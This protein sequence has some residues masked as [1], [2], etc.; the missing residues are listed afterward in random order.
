MMKPNIFNV[1]TKELSQDGFF[2]WLLQWADPS[3]D[4]YNKELCDCAQDFVKKLIAKQID[5]KTEI[6][7]VKAG[8]QWKNIDIWAEVNDEVLI[9][10]EDKTFTGEHSNQLETY[11][12]TATEWC[13]E[14]N[15]KLVC[16][17]LKTGSEALIS[18][19]KITNKGFAVV[20]RPE[21]ILFFNEH[22][23]VKSDIYTDFI[24]RLQSFEVLENSFK[25]LTIKEWH[26]NS[27]QGFYQF[28]QTKIDVTGWRYVA[29]PA[30]GFL[31]L[32][33]HFLEWKNYNVYLQI[34]QGNLCFKIGEVYDNHSSVRNE[35]SS[36]IMKH[37][38]QKGNHEIVK[39]QRFGS[40][41]YMTVAIIERKDWLG[42]DD[43]ILDKGKVV[44][45]LKEYEKFI[46]ECVKE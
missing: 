10:I 9:I 44:D 13:Q 11:K 7:K 27:W 15:Y 29:N 36:I 19:D 26:W 42:D 4:N 6:K 35:C 39:P 22:P 40:G 21:L 14:H 37:A 1:A 18:L 20:D 3:N 17:Y 33:W 12:K 32:W 28:L 16:I 38:Q 41:T 5:Y 23:L 34:E 24:E 2:T 43:S 46:D 31:G 25:N 30:G 45:K 8:R